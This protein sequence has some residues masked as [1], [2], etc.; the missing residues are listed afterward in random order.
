MAFRFFYQTHSIKHG[1]SFMSVVLIFLVLAVAFN[2]PAEAN[3]LNQLGTI[4]NPVILSFLS[5]QLEKQQENNKKTGKTGKISE[6]QYY[7]RLL[8]AITEREGIYF[9]IQQ[10]KSY[11]DSV[12]LFCTEKTHIAALGAITYNAVKNS[13]KL[14]ELLAV[15]VRNG[16]SIYFSGIFV[17]KKHNIQQARQLK[18]KTLALG[19]P[20]ST[21][22]FNYPL[23]MLID[24]GIQPEHDFTKIW[25]MHN[26]LAAIEKL[27]KGEAFAA[28]ASFQ[29]W[30]GAIDKGVINPL[31]FKPLLKSEPIPR[32]FT[33]I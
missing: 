25:I 30:K 29:S 22:S 4:N 16:E 31:N 26:H 15:E 21:S 14:A 9:K 3:E 32:L 13:C 23:A 28:A 7:T 33:L 2:K 24:E 10:S 17:H 27:A 6:A 11:E 8:A 1:C 20:Y 12:T 5:N 18:N 19:N